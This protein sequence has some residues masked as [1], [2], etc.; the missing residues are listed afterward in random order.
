MQAGAL[1]RAANERSDAGVRAAARG[2]R[3]DR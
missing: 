3:R 1:P 2:E